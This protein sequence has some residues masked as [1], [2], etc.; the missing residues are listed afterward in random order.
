VLKHENDRRALL[1]ALLSPAHVEGAYLF[2][3]TDSAPHPRANKEKSC[4]CAA[5]CFT[6]HATIELYTEAFEA[7]AA[8]RN[9]PTDVWQR[10]LQRFLTEDGARFYGLPLNS[11]R[12]IVLHK[13]AQQVPAT[14]PFGKDNTL[15]PLRAGQTIAWSIKS[16]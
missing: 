3:G 4:G 6:A 16:L 1:D 5:G 8:A 14:L 15:V 11:Q 13:Q 10:R 9:I 12:P 7:A 2:A